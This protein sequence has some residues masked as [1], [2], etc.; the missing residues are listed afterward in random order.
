MINAFFN[1]PVFGLSV[2]LDPRASKTFSLDWGTEWLDAGDAIL[3]TTWNADTGMTIVGSS[4]VNNITTVEL[5]CAVAGNYNVTNTVTTA[6]IAGSPGITDARTF[7][8]QV[9]EVR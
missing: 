4:M 1:D 8:V 3:T 7:T 9:R 2:L 6:G 5:M